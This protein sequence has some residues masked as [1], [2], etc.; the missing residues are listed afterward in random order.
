MDR[1][2]Y[3]K[4][5]GI[6]R[7]SGRYPWG[8]GENPQRN[9]GLRQEVKDLKKQGLSMKKIASDMGISMRQ[10]RANMSLERAAQLKADTAFA[11]RLL[12][13]GVSKTEIARRLG[14]N[15][16]TLRSMIDPATR[17]RALIAENTADML[18]Q[19]VEEKNYIDVGRGVE[20]QIGVARTKLDT[21]LI[22]LEQDGYSVQNIYIEQLTTPGGKK[23]T[24]RVLSKDDV[25]LQELYENAD[26]IKTVTEYTE[27][28]GRTY[29]AIEPIKCLSSDRLMVNF[30]E[31]GG[32]DK[33]GLIY[34]RRGQ[35]DL[36][37]GEARY[38][39]VRIGVDDTH[40]IKGMAVYSDDMPD[41]VDVIF[42]TNKSQS[43]GKLGA[44]KPLKDDPENPFSSIVRQRHYVDED[45][46]E[47]LSP[48]NVVNEEGTWDTWSRNLSSQF[49]SKQPTALAEKQLKL[50]FDLQKE[51]FDSIMELTNP[52]VRAAML[53]SF[54]DDCDSRAVHLKAAALPRQANKVILP[55]VSLKENECYNTM[56]DD[57]QK[58]ILVRHPHAGRFELPVV[59]VNNKN[60]EASDM[61]GNAVDA[62]G[63]H[64]STARSLSGADFDGDHVLTIPYTKDIITEPAL[65]RLSE[66]EPRIAYPAVPGHKR[67][68][69]S[70]TQLEMGKISN[71]ITDMTL[72]G[73][74]VDDV[75]RAVRHSMVVIDAEKHDLNYRQSFLDNS[76]A[77]LKTRYQGAPDAGA[78]T[79]ISRAKSE[80]YVSRRR[81]VTKEDMERDPSLRGLVRK[82]DYSVDPRTGKK[83]FVPTGET[84]VDKKGRVHTKKQKTPSTKMYETDDAH[85]LSTGTAMEKIY[86]DYANGMKGIAN[87]AR[88]ASIETPPLK[89]SPSARIAYKDEYQSLKAKLAQAEMNAPRER[90]AVLLSNKIMNSKT[91]LNPEMTKKE[92]K[93]EKGL[94][95]INARH[96]TSAKKDRVVFSDREWE[97]IQAGAI[98]KSMLTDLLKNANLDQVKSLATPR[99]KGTVS[100][101]RATRIKNLMASGYTQAQ[102]AK[103]VGVSTSMVSQVL[104]E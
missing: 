45:G 99:E 68:N 15:E 29:R 70:Q 53:D 65:Q 80:V 12:D 100:P 28:G 3:L 90:Q 41:G 24:F 63:I 40:F 60:A 20:H 74:P 37:L 64:P 13:K 9:R 25:S 4:H 2:P 87:A 11:T 32:A 10:L 1:A 78:A 56:Y 98:S 94:A 8:S 35:E 48:I 76:I 54:A 97:A 36:T 57:G 59:T 96:R 27:D 66:F 69:E 79:L 88:K 14:V 33:D 83:V 44:L 17:E 73:A 42:N 34:L 50:D 26:Q 84:W 47:Q 18:R 21:A 61:I 91:A 23:T 7:R 30:D 52:V 62:I 81:P 58:L 104:K 6:P 31:D 71:L 85:T 49:L 92:R 19:Q 55:V 46:N 86:G 77:D 89:Q 95:V 82:S 5:Y 43:V 39:Q 16:S 102:V 93:K 101:A 75:V 22:Q 72:Q 67:M 51:E 38:A 103:A